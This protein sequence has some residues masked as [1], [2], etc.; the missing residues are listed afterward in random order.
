MSVED[1]LAASATAGEE[2]EAYTKCGKKI[3]WEKK[4]LENPETKA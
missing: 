1:E 4:E 2:G 3:T